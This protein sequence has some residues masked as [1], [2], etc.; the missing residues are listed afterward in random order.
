MIGI[1]ITTAALVILIAAFNGIEGMVERLYSSYDAPLTI[2][3]QKGKTFKENTIDL[4]E[5]KKVEGVAE[6]SRAVEETVILKHQKKWVNAQMVGVDLNFLKTCEIEKHI[7]DGYPA[8]EEN[9]KPTAIIGASLLDKLEGYISEANGYEQLIIYTPLRD[10]SISRRKNPFKTT[11]LAISSRMNYNREVNSQ[12]IL[13]PLDF[14]QDQLNYDHEITALYLGIQPKA[15]AF[16]VKERLQKLL[17]P[18]FRVKTAAEKNELIYKTSQSE[19]R[20]VIIILVFVFILAAFNLIAS[21]TMLFI[22]KKDNIQ[23]MS[24]FG[25]GNGFI[26]RIFFFEG[27][28]IAGKGIVIGLALGTAVCLTQQYG[29]LLEMPNSGG[30]AFPIEFTVQDGL[31]ILVLV[32]SLSAI[33]AFLP[34]YYLVKRTSR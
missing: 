21:L 34:V 32:S 7:V 3:S 16:E 24:H 27:L 17:G 33:T 26:F 22:E 13:M 18:D 1:A 12:F 14:A 10:A 9:G 4:A 19:K 2:R 23:T 29:K 20:I 31:L 25:A 6:V 11:T 28:L 5:I 30:E 15:D 8:L